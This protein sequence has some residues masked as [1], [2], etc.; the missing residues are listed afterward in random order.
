MS[1]HDGPVTFGR[2]ARRHEPAQFTC[3]ASVFRDKNDTAR[4]AVEPIDE[5]AFG[6]TEMETHTADQARRFAV[7]RRVT[8]ESSRLVQ[9]KQVVVLMKDLQGRGRSP[10]AYERP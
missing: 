8:D 6:V 1:V 3:A 10:S 2:S 5:A 7:A 9:D 4:L